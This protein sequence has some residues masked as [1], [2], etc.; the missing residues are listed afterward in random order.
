MESEA[1]ILEG[2]EP[3]EQTAEGAAAAEEE[4]AAP[5]GPEEP[6]APSEMVELTKTQGS[7]T[8][9]NQNRHLI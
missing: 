1:P 2:G 9:P 7:M 3:Q 4:G 5:P 6:T 8:A